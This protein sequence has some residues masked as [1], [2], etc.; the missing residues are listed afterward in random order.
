MC[1]KVSLHIACMTS[2]LV[3]W[4]ADT[5]ALGARFTIKHDDTKMANSRRNKTMLASRPTSAQ[6]LTLHTY[7]LQNINLAGAC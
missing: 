5:T 3:K 2:S 1:Y 4:R 7:I 6:A